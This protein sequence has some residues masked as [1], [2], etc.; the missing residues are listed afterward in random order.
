MIQYFAYISLNAVFMYLFF[1]A[2][3]YARLVQGQK[4]WNLISIQQVLNQTIIIPINCKTALS[5]TYC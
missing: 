5:Y 4:Y 2:T 3:L 1:Y